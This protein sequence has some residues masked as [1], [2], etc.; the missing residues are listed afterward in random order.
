MLVNVL[1]EKGAGGLYLEQIN[2]IPLQAV[3]PFLTRCHSGNEETGL[4]NGQTTLNCVL[5][6]VRS[7]NGI[8]AK[9]WPRDRVSYHSATWG[10]ISY[11]VPSPYICLSRP[12]SPRSHH[13]HLHCPKAWEGLCS[14]GV[15]LSSVSRLFAFS[16]SVYSLTSTQLLPLSL[17]LPNLGYRTTL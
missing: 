6:T 4:G 11:K 9:L 8:A 3:N 13:H 12:P 2:S 17:P 16:I 1:K 15:D 7:P 5:P 10:K 14:V